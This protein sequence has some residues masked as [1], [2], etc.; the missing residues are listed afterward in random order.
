M[1]SKKKI[2]VKT[3]SLDPV[4]ENLEFTDYA[5][6]LIGVIKRHYRMIEGRNVESP[7]ILDIATQIIKGRLK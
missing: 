5:D 4:F 1:P 6:K 2:T 7:E 3:E